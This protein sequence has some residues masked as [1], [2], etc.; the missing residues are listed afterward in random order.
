MTR[1]EFYYK[2]LP[3]EQRGTF[4]HKVLRETR[5][6]EA[7]FYRILKFEPGKLLKEK[8]S[9]FSGITTKELYSDFTEN[10]TPNMI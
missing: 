10:L 3:L 1:L 8:L 5:I 9:E 2:N 4:K 6:S 7:T